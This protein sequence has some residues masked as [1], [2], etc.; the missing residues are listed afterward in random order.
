MIFKNT[1]KAQL[2]SKFKPSL[3]DTICDD[4]SMMF[5]FVKCEPQEILVKEVPIGSEEELNVFEVTYEPVYSNV[6]IIYQNIDGNKLKDDE[7][8][9][10]QVGT[11]Y[12]PK[13]IQFVKDRRGIQWENIT[14]EVDTIRVMENSKDNIVKM[15][16]ELAKA[17]VLVKYKNLEGNIIKE[18]KRYEENIGTE[19][20]PEVENVIA[21][22]KNRKWIFS[23]AEPVKITVGS[24]NNV[25]T[26]TYL[27][28]RVPVTI[29]YE[30]INGKKLREDVI[31]NVQEGT[32][33]IP[34]KNYTIIY[35]E[36]EIWKYLELDR[37]HY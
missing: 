5:R 26:L 9:Q 1:E 24:I 2:G 35:D 23:A 29:R 4:K 16:F 12:T 19:F 34:K 31:V 14:K 25:I 18:S 22:S 20:V 21:D 10:L 15:T 6:S 13:L 11:K 8:I 7:I 3:D 36:N 17:E 32:Q 37:L 27:E 33:F 28:K 30:S